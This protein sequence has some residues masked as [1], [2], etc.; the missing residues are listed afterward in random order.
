MVMEEKEGMAQ[1]QVDEEKRMND[2][3]NKR[4]NMR[5]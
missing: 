5:K 1:S 2:R 3:D 4:K